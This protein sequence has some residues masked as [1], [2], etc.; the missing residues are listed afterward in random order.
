MYLL[1]NNGGFSMSTMLVFLR[2]VLTGMILQVSFNHNHHN[3][4]TY[5]KHQKSPPG[6]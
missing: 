4:R 1:L 2:G 6:P 3:H 5:L